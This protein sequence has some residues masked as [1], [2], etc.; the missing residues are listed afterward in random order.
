MVEDTFLA[1]HLARLRQSRS[2]T[3]EDLA[4][5]S[6]VSRATLS[7][8]E[9]GQTSPTAAVL[10]Q[11]AAVYRLPVAALF[12][13]QDLPGPALVRCQDQSVWT[14]PDTG[15]VRRGVSPSVSGFR[16]TVIEGE[17]PG[18]KTVA[19]R[20]SPLPDLEHHLV[21][22]SGRLT[23]TLAEGCFEME[24]GDCLRFRLNAANSYHAPGPESAR[25]LLC[26]IG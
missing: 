20:T 8:I 9:R 19:Y 10:G 2:L 18:G 12:A 6:G 7:R 22:L 4:E 11:L 15:F 17:V 1:R 25:Y 3:L 23:V 13:D 14:D 5:R 26:V 16:G 24:P 21:V